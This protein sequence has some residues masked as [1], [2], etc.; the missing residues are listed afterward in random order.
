MRRTRRVAHLLLSAAQRW[1][2]HGAPTRSAAIAFYSLTSMAPVS[3]LLVWIG[4]IAW[5]SAATR[6]QILE[7]IARSAGSETA[8][9]V[10][11]VLQ[12]ASM[13]RGGALLPTVIAL[14]VFGFSATAVF[15]QL[16]GALRDTWGIRSAPGPDVSGFIRG[17]ILALV[18]LSLLGVF[19]T[20]SMAARVVITAL[21]GLLP[22]I[23]P[24]PLAYVADMAISAVTLMVLF[25]LVFK[26]LP[27]ADVPW[28]KAT[29]GG[30]LTGILFVAGQWVAGLYLGRTGVGSAYGAAGSLIVFLFWV[31]YS[32]L[33]FLFGAE[34]T[35]A[36][37][38]DLPTPSDSDRVPAPNLD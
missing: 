33:V 26:I 22:S 30:I 4:G 15:S 29:L 38:N 8:S 35:H 14:I 3:L 1:A 9:L 16:Q 20:L 37:G 18:V 6:G 17:R 11:S 19:L 2:D 7:W 13:P 27:E 31:Y 25:T 28:P 23:L 36:L 5:E 24:F 10:E 21:A 12:Q 34:V 32:S